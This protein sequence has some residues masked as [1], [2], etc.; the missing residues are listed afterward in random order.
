MSG[1]CFEP[2]WD[3]KQMAAQIIEK[4]HPHL[5]DALGYIGFYFRDGSTDWMG[6][7]SKATAFERHMT[8]NILL[9]FIN[10][11]DWKRL[12]PDQRLALVDHEL[13]HIDRAPMVAIDP[14]TKEMVNTWEAAE[15]PDSWRIKDHDVEEFADIIR[16]HGLW[17][18]T[19]E[20]FGEAVRDAPHQMNLA[21]VLRREE[22]AQDGSIRRVK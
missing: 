17:D 10:A 16:R 1:T 15:E 11:A 3:V 2:A 19:R 7:C 4:H 9:I 20:K 22:E 6:K 13:T 21:D 8:G 18:A 5:E 12:M 14:I